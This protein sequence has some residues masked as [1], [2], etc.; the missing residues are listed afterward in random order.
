MVITESGGVLVRTP[1]SDYNTNRQVR[2]ITVRMNRDGSAISTIET[3]YYGL[4]CDAMIPVL[5]MDNEDK[6]RSIHDRIMIPGCRVESF[7][8]A[9][10]RSA[11]PSVTE[12]LKLSFPVFGS[13]MDGKLILRPDLMTR[14]TDL[15]LRSALRKSPVMIRRSLCEYDTATYIMTRM[16]KPDIL[17]KTFSLTSSFGEYSS[18]YYTD[19]NKLICTRSL[20]L[21][22]GRYPVEAYDAFAEFFEKVN[23]EDRRQIIIPGF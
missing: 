14:V 7:S 9:E 18:G 3:S 15:P 20:K 8:Y 2:N 23:N 22:K 5:R 13:A 6:K 16:I 1:V 19:G 17:P 4:K 10:D 11:I 12:T 21:N